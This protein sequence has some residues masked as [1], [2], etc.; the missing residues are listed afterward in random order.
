MK[1]EIQDKVFKFLEKKGKNS[2]NIRVKGCSSWGVGEPQPVVMLGNPKDEKFNLYNQDG[3]DVYVENSV[4]AK[5]DI[6]KIRI[7]KIL[8]KEILVVENLDI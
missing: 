2:I 5:D 1:I 3:V 8:F 4:K 6:L 7:S